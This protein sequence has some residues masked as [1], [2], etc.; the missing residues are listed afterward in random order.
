MRLSYSPEVSAMIIYMF[1]RFQYQIDE[2]IQGK[3][4]ESFVLRVVASFLRVQRQFYGEEGSSETVYG[5]EG[6]SSTGALQYLS[7]SS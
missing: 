2:L 6:S 1:V 7:N 3:L 5:E 4:R